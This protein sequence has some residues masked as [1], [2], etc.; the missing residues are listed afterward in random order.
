VDESYGGCAVFN[1]YL[2]MLCCIHS[3]KSA[4]ERGNILSAITETCL[5]VSP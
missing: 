2:R 5:L 3:N 1:K 4:K